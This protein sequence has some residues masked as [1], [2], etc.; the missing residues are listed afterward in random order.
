VR[1]GNKAAF[2]AL[3]LT[4]CFSSRWILLIRSYFCIFL[5]NAKGFANGGDGVEKC[6]KAEFFHC[7]AL[8]LDEHPRFACMLNE[9]LRQPLE[10]RRVAISRPRH[11]VEYPTNFIFVC[12]M[13]PCLCVYYT[14]QSKEYKCSPLQNQ[15]YMS[16]IADCFVF[17]VSA[18]YSEIVG[19]QRDP[20]H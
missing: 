4:T 3:A 11:P 1:G 2:L 19:H 9:V 7:E 10:D 5:Q 15:K 6:R 20:V 8:F 13:N 17:R 12:I 18:P 16:K 14:N